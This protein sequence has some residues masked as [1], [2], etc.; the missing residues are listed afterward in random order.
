MKSAALLFLI[1]LTANIATAVP[2]TFYRLTFHAPPKPLSPEATTEDW[3]R[4]LGPRHDLHSK[5]TH[6]LKSWPTSGPKVVWEVKRGTGH[7]PAV[8]S[9][10]YLVMIHAMDGQEVVECLQ[11]ETGKRYWKF[12]YPVR[13][14]SN[15]GISD[16]PR[17]GPVIDGDLVFTVGVR[18]DLHCFNLKTGAVVWK[19]NLDQEYGP[20]PLFFGRG[21]C[22]LV[23]GDQ[24]IVN[25]GGQFC[26]G[27]FDKRTGKLLW[28]TKHDWQSSYA[29]PVPATLNGKQRVLVFAGG[30]LRPAAGGLLSIDP[31]SGVLEAAFPWRANMYTS[32][33]AASPVVIGN[34]VFITEGYTEGGAL[35]DFS[36]DGSAK[37]RWKA[38]RFGSQFT[39]PV[40]HDGYLYGVVGTGGTEMVCYEIKSGRELWRDGIKLR[41]ARLGRASLLRVDGAFLCIGDQGTLIW[42]DLSPAGAKILAQAQLFQAPETCTVFLFGTVIDE[43]LEWDT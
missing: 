17:S 29:S 43:H 26:V 39:T 42:L 25:V 18:S 41:D 27:S 7:A 30:M 35:V 5:E 20:A 37:L 23:Y 1:L 13:L 3:P 40:A 11:P 22:P 16:A 14:S 6:L 8:V 4:F 36:P 38:E 21:S 32:V 15:Y 33:N 10:D 34:S 28:S 2:E 19:K 24:L 12:E 31:E 9:G